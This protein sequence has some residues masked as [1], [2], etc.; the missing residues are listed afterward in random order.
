M[1]LEYIVKKDNKDEF[2]KRLDEFNPECKQLS[3]DSF[4]I[5]VSQNGNSEQS[6]K[7]LSDLNDKVTDLKPI[8]LTNGS[9]AYFNKMLFPLVN[10]FERKLRKLLYASSAISQNK[11]DT[12]ANLEELDFGEIFELLFLDRE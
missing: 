11:K 6:A 10:N 3:D 12:I 1:L 5:S 8:V 9:A 4:F 2:I 7:K